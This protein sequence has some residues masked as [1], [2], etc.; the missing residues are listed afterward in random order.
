MSVLAEAIGLSAGYSGVA[1][2]EDV[3]FRVRPGERVALLGPNGGGN[4]PS[5]GLSRGAR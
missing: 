5:A 4:A 3:S 2:I 1:A